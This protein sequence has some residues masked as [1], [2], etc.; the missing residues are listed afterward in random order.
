MTICVTHTKTIQHDTF[1]A[2]QPHCDNAGLVKPIPAATVV[3]HLP[4]K[5]NN[6]YYIIASN[7]HMNQHSS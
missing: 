3:S 7:K 4:V 2:I 1:E 6:V 5:T